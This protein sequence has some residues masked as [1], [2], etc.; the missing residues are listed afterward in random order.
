[1]PELATDFQTLPP[2]YQAVLRLAQ[3]TYAITVAPLQLLVGGWSGA[4]V[5]LVS[6]SSNAT[7]LVEHCILKLDRKGKS[8][9]SDEVT[10]HNTVMGKST[11][12]FA[13]DHI[14]ELVFDRVEHEGAIAIFY[15]I[16][17]QSLLKYLSLIEVRTPKP[18]QNDFY[19]RPIRCSAGGVECGCYIPAGRSS[20]KGT[21]KMAGLSPGCRG[22]Y[23]TL[24]AGD[25]SG[26]PGRSRFSDQWT[27]LPQS[28]AP[29]PQ[30]GTVGQGPLHGCCHRLHPWRFEHEQHLGQI[31]RRTRKS[32]KATT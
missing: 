21:G 23:R 1:M 27:C 17:G 11:P 31:L 6:V 24:P 15:R 8:A 4:V 14:A 26:Q 7:N 5:Y 20:A 12:A 25:L 32:L 13:R 18:A 30:G 19:T 10:R 29:R 16:A 22:E 2:E 28:I 9:K 3:D